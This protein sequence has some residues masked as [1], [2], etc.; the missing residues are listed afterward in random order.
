MKQETQEVVKAGMDAISVFTM[1]GALI[2]LLPALAALV[3]IVWTSIRIYE[4]RT[5]QEWLKKRKNN[6]K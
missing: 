5:V 3:T 4:T 1:L 2:Q 6:A